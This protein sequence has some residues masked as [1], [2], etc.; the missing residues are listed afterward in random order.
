MNFKKYILFTIL[1]SL[2]LSLNLTSFGE[3][4]NDKKDEKN[5][6][7]DNILDLDPTKI[8]DSVKIL[9]PT[10]ILDPKKN[11]DPTKILDN[12]ETIIKTVKPINDNINKNIYDLS[13]LTEEDENKLGKEIEKTIDKSEKYKVTKQNKFDL[14][15]ILNK[16]LEN[17]ERKK[18]N[19]RYVIVE[20][21]ESN[22]F[23]IL[24]G[25]IYIY[26]GLIELMEKEDEMA[27]ILAHEI[28]HNELKQTIY[29]IQSGLLVGNLNST[30]GNIVQTAYNIYRIPFSKYQEFDADENAIKLLKKSGYT[31]EGGISSFEK[32]EKK[33]V[34]KKNGLDEFLST[35]ADPKERK[36]KLKDY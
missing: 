14:D 32:L 13:G 2:I 27:F 1:F 15:K 28:S 9:D 10:K 6:N 34:D 3:T 18:I 17:V 20:N 4:N 26:T 30:A 25:K 12:A 7:E 21:K 31:K 22:A 36:E 8:L 24:G 19:Y 5:K 11:I 23:T 29:A 35:H 33:Y 16:L